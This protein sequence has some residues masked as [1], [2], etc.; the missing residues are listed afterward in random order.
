ML[1]KLFLGCVC[2]TTLT[3]LQAQQDTLLYN[4]GMAEIKNNHYKKAITYFNEA[5]S[6]NK[7]YAEAYDARGGCYAEL[8][9]TD[10]ALADYNTELGLKPTAYA[11]N[12]I[13]ML[14]YRRYDA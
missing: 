6:L 2:V 10:K 5:I 1:T 8:D 11:Y 12:S 7:K 4:Q 13:G 9:E 3:H 14:H